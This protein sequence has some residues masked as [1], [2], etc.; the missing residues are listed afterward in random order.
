MK[1]KRRKRKS[2]SKNSLAATTKRKGIRL[3]RFNR[4]ICPQCRVVFVKET[5]E[6]KYCGYI[7]EKHAEGRRANGMKF[8]SH[9][10]EPKS[11]DKRNLLTLEK[12]AKEANT[13]WLTRKDPLIRN[14]NP[15]P[16]KE[17]IRR[18]EYKRVF[19]DKGWNHYLKGKK[20]DR[21]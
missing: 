21:I 10:G 20:W 9:V 16:L 14:N 1:S 8:R 18:S 5:E 4:A 12:K 7:C 17:L 11:Y 6:Q 13:K 19:D 3:A 15:I 2:P